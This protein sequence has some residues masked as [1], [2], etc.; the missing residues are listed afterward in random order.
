MRLCLY[1]SGALPFSSGSRRDFPMSS[2]SALTFLLAAVLFA[3]GGWW[4]WNALRGREEPAP[5]AP[6]MAASEPVA[7]A[8]APAQPAPHASYPVPELAGTPALEA[9]ELRG[10][11]DALLGPQAGAG[12]L[13]LDDLARRLAAT[14][15]NLGRAHAPA[16]LWPTLPTPGRFT[17]ETR[18]GATV[19]AA[20][21]AARYTPF[22]LFV[23]SID[24][25]RAVDLYVRMYP[26]LQSAYRQL[27]YPGRSFNDRLIEVID[28]LLAA[29]EIEGPVRLDL[30]EVKGP[31]PAERPWVR[32]EFAHPQLESLPA[33]Q[34]IM[35]RIGVANERRLKQRLAE[36]R[37]E[38]VERGR[39]R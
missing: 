1:S 31:I 30:M 14:V 6:P 9:G 2:R 28:L 24:V 27:G 3:A 15:D 33:G 20:G 23:E 22:V 26:L 18:D 11:V 36:V 8:S 5:A 7:A 19:I 12:F 25:Q 21:N 34:K 35:V 37:R 10:A 38:I 29:P 17:V 13:Q 16:I 32:Y 4:M 39:K